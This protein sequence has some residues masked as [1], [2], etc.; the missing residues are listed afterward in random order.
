MSVHPDHQKRG[1]GS[2]LME[3]VCKEADQLC[4]HV[5]VLASPAGANLYSK[6]DFETVDQIITEKGI[7]KSMLRRADK[8]RSSL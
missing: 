3:H 6:F 2:I 1:V 8:S 5:Y 7:I 4:A